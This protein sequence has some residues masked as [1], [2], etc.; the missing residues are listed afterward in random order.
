MSLRIVNKGAVAEQ[1]SKR[2]VH[3]PAARKILYDTYKGKEHVLS[4]GEADVMGGGK[5]KPIDRIQDIPMLRNSM[6]SYKKSYERG[7]PITLT[8]AARNALWIK[9]KRLKD[10]FTRSMVSKSDMH[11]VK[12]RQIVKNGA[13]VEAV[14]VDKEKMKNTRALERNK[15]WCKKN[16]P[17]VKEFKRIMRVLEPHNEKITD[18][19]RFRPN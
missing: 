19:E 16:D 1:D 15:A 8:P 13:A 14:V 3:A 10:E 17:K 7:A 18:I 11:P 9:A 6:K 5:Y 12:M 4:G 2:E